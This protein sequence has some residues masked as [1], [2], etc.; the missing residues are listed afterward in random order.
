[1]RHGL[2]E[3]NIQQR[4]CGHSDIP[5]AAQGR[6]QAL[7]IAEQLQQASIVAIY[8]SDLLRARETAEIIAS[9]RT[10]VI[11]I[12]AS[13]E[14]REMDFGAWEGLTYMQIVEQFKD[15]LAFFTDPEHHAPPHG[16]SLFH[17]KRR[18]MDALSAMLH[19]NASPP[20]DIVIVSHGGP[21][22]ILLCSLLGMSLSRQWQLRLDPGSISAID[23]LPG[24]EILRCAQ[25][26]RP[27]RHNDPG[28]CHS[29]RSEESEPR[30]TLALLNVQAPFSIRP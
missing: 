10:Q 16:E 12:K 24:S 15:H 14:W 30:A 1:M 13:A 11:Q 9:R 29:E 3:W 4:Y 18:V 27:L 21:L 22:R 8:A 25:N 28:T 26:D 19:D 17:L 5:L 2:T 7:W 6:E 23:L 20:G